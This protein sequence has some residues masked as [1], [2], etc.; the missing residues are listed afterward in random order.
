MT[1][2]KLTKRET[3]FIEAL[4]EGTPAAD[5][6]QTAF[7]TKPGA[8]RNALRALASALIRKPHIAGALK[9]AETAARSELA[10]SLKWS[11][12]KSVSVRLKAFD[13]LQADIER[14]AD[15][16][17]DEINAIEASDQPDKAILSARTRQRVI[18][19]REE[20]K[21]ISAACDALDRLCKVNDSD[22]M[23]PPVVIIDDIA[24]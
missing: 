5:A 20:L 16:L 10:H 2:G 17:K 6:Y 13:A 8:K 21:A 23:H 19:G 24:D 11:L 18:F 15:A 9:D 1:I 14:R 3:A 7:Q 22:Y 12:E 4:I